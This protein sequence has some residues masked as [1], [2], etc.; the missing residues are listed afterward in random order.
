MYRFSTAADFFLKCGYT[1]A[2]KDRLERYFSDYQEF[3]RT[4]GNQR[5][6][7]IGIPMIMIGT[8]GLLALII[9]CRGP[10]M[11]L[12]QLDGGLILWLGASLWYV[13]LDWRLGVPFSSLTLSTS[14]F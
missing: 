11:P 1:H 14:F 2:M 5:C 9:S 3:H 7:L 12:L 8:L 13:F 6:H 10:S 4:R